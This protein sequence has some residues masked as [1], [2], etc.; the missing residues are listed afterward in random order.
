MRLNREMQYSFNF[1][2]TRREET[3]LTL[4]AL[5]ILSSINNGQNSSVNTQKI[6]VY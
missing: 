3:V 5:S 1:S 6:V 2:G 4:D